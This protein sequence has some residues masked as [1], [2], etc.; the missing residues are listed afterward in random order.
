MKF[1]FVKKLCLVSIGLNKCEIW[2][3]DVVVLAEYVIEKKHKPHISCHA[4]IDY[5]E[6]KLV[7]GSKKIGVI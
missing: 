4:K 1:V 7:V 6:C 3:M 2:I 5:K